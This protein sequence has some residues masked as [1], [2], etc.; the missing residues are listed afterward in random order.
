MFCDEL[1]PT[2]QKTERRASARYCEGSNLTM[3]RSGGVEEGVFMA[4]FLPTVIT[5]EHTHSTV[6]IPLRRGITE[7]LLTQQ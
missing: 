6:K 4:K 7:L 2:T 3:A 5:R 1:I